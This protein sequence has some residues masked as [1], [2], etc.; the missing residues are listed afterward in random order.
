MRATWYVLETGETA[1]PCEVA[2]DAKGVLR[3]KS[4]AA[5]AMKG[6]VPHSIGVDL[7]EVKAKEPEPAKE[8]QPEKPKRAYKTRDMK[9]D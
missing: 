8:M 3:H 7:D 6:Q 5:V 1:D 4:G 2:P 9:A